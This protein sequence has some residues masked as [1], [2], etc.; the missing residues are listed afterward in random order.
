MCWPLLRRA[1]R[2]PAEAYHEGWAQSRQFVNG[3]NFEGVEL[4][5]GPDWGGPLFFTHYSFC[6]I[7]PRGLSD[8]YADYWRQNVAHTRINYAYCVRNPLGYKGYGPNCWGLTAG[9]SIKGYDA[10]SPSNDKSVIT[11]SGA[12]ASFPYAPDGGDGGAAA[13]L[14]QSRRQDLGP[15]RLHR[16]FQRAA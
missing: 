16:R 2:W 8:A 11:P 12:L 5:L 10:H 15:L 3:R 9:D 14:R 6:G 7:D 13:L 4:P 1:I